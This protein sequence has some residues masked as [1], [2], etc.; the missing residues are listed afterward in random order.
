MV[1]V[2]GQDAFPALDLLQ[3]LLGSCPRTAGAA[4]RLGEGSCVV[5]AGLVEMLISL[6]GSQLFG[7]QQKVD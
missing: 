6:L 5:F 2:K 3:L 7:C 4:D 1:W